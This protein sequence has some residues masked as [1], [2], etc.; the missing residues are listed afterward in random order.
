MLELVTAFSLKDGKEEE[1]FK[2]AD[3]IKKAFNNLLPKGASLSGIWRQGFGE[4]FK[5][6][7]RMQVDDLNILN[8]LS[9]STLEIWKLIQPYVNSNIPKQLYSIRKIA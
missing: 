4:L 6:E 9:E 7:F 3:H 2:S 1:F 5:I 8:G